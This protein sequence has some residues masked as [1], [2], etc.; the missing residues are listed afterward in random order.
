MSKLLS[1]FFAVFLLFG[2]FPVIDANAHSMF[3]SAEEVLGD[4]RVQ[5][6]T[7]PEIPTTGE[8]SQ[9]LFRVL[10]RDENEVDR[11]TMGLRIFFDDIQI[12]SVPMAS[13]IGGHWETDYVFENSGNHIFRVDLYDAGKDGGTLT[14][15]FNVSTH[16]PFGYIFFYSIAAGSMG[17]AIIFGYIY[18]PKRLKSRSK[19]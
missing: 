3:N 10:D 5:I 9:I 4:Y 19:P 15:T 2:L 1:C 18:I 12:D 6:A 7:L 11:F 14:Y 13:H 17:L 16:N 8:T